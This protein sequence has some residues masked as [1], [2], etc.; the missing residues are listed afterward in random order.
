MFFA[1][2]DSMPK[3]LSLIEPEINLFKI[4]RPGFWDVNTLSIQFVYV[5]LYCWYNFATKKNRS[6]RPALMFIDYLK[7]GK[8]CVFPFTAVLLL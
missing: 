7:M 8:R 6:L 5:L 2:D 1:K 3:F 4:I